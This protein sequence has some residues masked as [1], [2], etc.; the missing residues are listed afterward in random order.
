MRRYH[1]GDGL[2]QPNKID[3]FDKSVRV[4]IKKDLAKKWIK[5]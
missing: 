2:V 4:D 3:D 5:Q 1:G